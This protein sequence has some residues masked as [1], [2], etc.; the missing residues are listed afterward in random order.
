MVSRSRCVPGVVE[1][2]THPRLEPLPLTLEPF[3][4]LDDT[5]AAAT[6]VESE[7]RLERAVLAMLL[8]PLLDSRKRILRPA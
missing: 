2:L 4:V 1:Q 5:I 3:E 8:A 7:V 6:T